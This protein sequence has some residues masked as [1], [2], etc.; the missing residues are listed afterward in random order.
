MSGWRQIASKFFGLRNS[1]FF[2][3]I[4]SKISQLNKILTFKSINKFFP[5][6]EQ[7]HFPNTSFAWFPHNKHFAPYLASISGQITPLTFRI[8]IIS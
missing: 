1:N 7:P 5:L 8:G 3:E 6:I 2:L 4:K